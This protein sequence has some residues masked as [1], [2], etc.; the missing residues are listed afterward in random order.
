[1]CISTTSALDA[2][3]TETRHYKSAMDSAYGITSL[4]ETAKALARGTHPKRAIV[5]LAFTSEE[6]GELAS[7]FY[8]H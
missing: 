1:M 4:I 7:Q 5:F 8:A 6:E 2:Q 3:G